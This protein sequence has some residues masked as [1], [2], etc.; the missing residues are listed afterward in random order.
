MTLPFLAEC[1]QATSSKSL[2]QLSTATASS[3]CDWLLCPVQKALFAPAFP[4]LWYSP[5]L[6]LFLC[7]ACSALE[8]KADKSCSIWRLSTPQ[9]FIFSTVTELK[10]FF[11]NSPWKEGFRLEGALSFNAEQNIRCLGSCGSFIAIRV[12]LLHFGKVTLKSGL[13]PVL[14]WS[15]SCQH[16]WSTSLQSP[17][18]IRKPSDRQSIALWSPVSSWS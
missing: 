6:Y 9:T 5:S 4:D 17:W 12:F 8:E 14:Y 10:S 3:E 7:D 11:F 15:H 16:W 1:C 13:N 18:I 2:V